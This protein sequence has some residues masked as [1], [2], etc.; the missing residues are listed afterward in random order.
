M[1]DAPFFSIIVDTTQDITKT[2]QLSLI[3]RYLRIN[4]GKSIEINE[5]FVGFFGVKNQS[6]KDIYTLILKIINA[7]SVD[8][9]KCRGQGY[10][11]AANMKGK[12]IGLQAQIKKISANAARW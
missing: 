10:D 2:D 3:L 7:C 12:Y 8:I 5:A 1:R 9:K 4:A 6:G 11:G